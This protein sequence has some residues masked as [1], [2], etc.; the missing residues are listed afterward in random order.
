MNTSKENTVSSVSS[1]S[2]HQDS[3]L[4]CQARLRLESEEP[5]FHSSHLNDFTTECILKERT[6]YEESDL[7]GL[8]QVSVG[9]N[10]II[11]IFT[12]V[13]EYCYQYS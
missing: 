4:P 8:I 7:L 12:D 5:Q 11:Q 2:L 9:M 1:V 13:S 3:F 10:I 6:E